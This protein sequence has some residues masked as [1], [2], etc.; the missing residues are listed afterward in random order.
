MIVR[1]LKMKDYFVKFLINN[2]AFGRG[3]IEEER[4]ERKSYKQK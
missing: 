4:K 2:K 1:F 3:G